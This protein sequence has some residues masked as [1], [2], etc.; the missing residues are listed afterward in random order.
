VD[1]LKGKRRLF[2]LGSDKATAKE[3]LKVFE[4]RNVRREDFDAEKKAASAKVV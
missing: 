2:P 1:R 4:A 3:K